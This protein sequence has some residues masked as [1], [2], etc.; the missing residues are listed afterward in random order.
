MRKEQAP[1]GRVAKDARILA[2][3]DREGAPSP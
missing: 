2:A 3:G 1:L